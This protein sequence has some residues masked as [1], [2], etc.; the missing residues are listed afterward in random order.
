MAAPTRWC[1]G[2][3]RNPQPATNAS[4]VRSIIEAS[5]VDDDRLVIHG[6]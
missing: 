4:L 6:S 2:S 1:R 5:V 3:W